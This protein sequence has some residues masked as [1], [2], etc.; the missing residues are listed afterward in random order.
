MSASQACK[1]HFTTSCPSFVDDFQ[2]RFH[3]AN[4]TVP[5]CSISAGPGSSEHN[6]FTYYSTLA[7]L[8]SLIQ[9][10]DSSAPISHIQRLIAQLTLIFWSSEHWRIHNSAK[11]QSDNTSCFGW[12]DVLHTRQGLV[13]KLVGLRPLW[14]IFTFTVPVW[15]DL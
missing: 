6:C 14:A 1:Q 9:A 10:C 3:F 4:I 13:V 5:Y 12:V 11:D 15:A 7:S 2:S 8:A